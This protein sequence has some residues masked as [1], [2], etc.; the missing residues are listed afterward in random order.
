VSGHTFSGASMPSTLDP[1]F[2]LLASSSPSRLA[3]PSRELHEPAGLAGPGGLGM[4]LL[5]RPVGNRHWRRRSCPPA[6]PL[7]SRSLFPDAHLWSRRS[8]YFGHG[9]TAVMIA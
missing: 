9:E 4:L 5:L 2:F 8:H 6:C 7:F 1:N 3:T